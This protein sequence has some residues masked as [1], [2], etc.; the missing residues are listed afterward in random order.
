MCKCLSSNDGCEYGS[1]SF[2][3]TC[4]GI[5]LEGL[6]NVMG[7]FGECNWPVDGSSSTKATWELPS[8]DLAIR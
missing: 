7:N 6:R 5:Y 1:R 8:R 3:G 2:E 4:A